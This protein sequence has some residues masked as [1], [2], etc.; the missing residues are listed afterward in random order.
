MIQL[1]DLILFLYT[2]IKKIKRLLA[3]NRSNVIMVMQQNGE[4]ASGTDPVDG[5]DTNQEE[6]NMERN[7][8]VNRL[9][10]LEEANITVFEKLDNM[11]VSNDH[12]FKKL[13]DMENAIDSVN[14]LNIR[15]LRIFDAQNIETQIYVNRRKRNSN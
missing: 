8:M 13:D 5:I 11:T 7:D 9:S 6:G 10:K 4:E 12:I 15:V 1:P 14:E 3:I 2:R